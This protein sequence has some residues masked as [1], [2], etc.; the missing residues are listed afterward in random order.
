VRLTRSMLMEPITMMGRVEVMFEVQ[1]QN[2]NIEQPTSNTE[3]PR[4]RGNRSTIR[5]I[6]AEYS[7]SRSSRSKTRAVRAPFFPSMLDVRCS[8]FDVRI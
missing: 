8:V 6:S 4:V 2:A 3:H 5:T 7:S 1:N